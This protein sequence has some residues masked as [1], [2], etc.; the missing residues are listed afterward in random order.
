[1]KFHQEASSSEG[2]VAQAFVDVLFACLMNGAT[3]RQ[4]AECAVPAFMRNGKFISSLDRPSRRLPYREWAG[5]RIRVLER[6]DYTCV[7]CG[8]AADH[9]DHVHPISKG[10]SNNDDNLAAACAHCNISKGGKLL[11]EWRG[12]Q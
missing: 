12:K 11:S 6:D 8:D 9:V 7:Y 1:M 3:A 2:E 4:A 10:G 5:V